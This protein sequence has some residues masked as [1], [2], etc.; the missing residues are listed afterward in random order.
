M[1]NIDRLPFPELIDEWI[2]SDKNHKAKIVYRKCIT[3]GKF[4]LA[5]KISNKYRINQGLTDSA[6]AMGMALKFSQK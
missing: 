2:E 1:R 4:S 3:A 6:I 5:R